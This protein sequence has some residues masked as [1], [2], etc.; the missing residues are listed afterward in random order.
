M[1]PVIVPVISRWQIEDLYNKRDVVSFD[2]ERSKSPVRY[3]GNAARFSYNGIEYEISLDELPDV[4]EESCEVYALIED[5]WRELSIAGARFYKLCV[6]NRG[7][8]P[9]LMID[10]ITMHSVLENPLTITAY[11]IEKARGRVF[12]CCTGLGYTTIEALKKGARHIITVELD[13]NVLTLAM[14]NPYSRELWSP[15]VDIAVGDCI[16]FAE[17]LR[18]S[19]FDYIIHDPPRLSYATQRLYSESLYRDFYRL[20]RRGGGLFHY[21]SQSGM[22]YRGLNPYRGVVERLKRTGFVI[23]KVK[24][25]YGIY[26]RKR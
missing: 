9:T 18:D 14:F 19:A 5:K 17:T 26:A 1:G 22:K 15:Q 11:K 23:E 6:F 12:E 2:L 16:S 13:T 7:W 8:A 3:V 4:D 20:L 25:G 21:V 24:E 10:G